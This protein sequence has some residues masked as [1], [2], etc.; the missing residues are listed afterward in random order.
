MNSYLKTYKIILTT[1]APVFIG[2]GKDLNKKEYI[3]EY[4]KSKVHIPDFAKMF[5]FINKTHRVEKFQDYMLNYRGDFSR[6]LKDNNIFPQEYMQWIDYSLFVDE[7]VFEDGGKNEIHTC[8]KDAYGCPYIPGS[9]LKGAIRTAL[10]ANDILKNKGK[11]SRMSSDVMRAEL[12]GRTKMLRQETDRIEQTA[13]STLNRVDEKGKPIKPSNAVNDVM[14]GIRISDSKPLDKNCLILC[15][16]I[17]ESTTGVQKYMP[18][19]RE[20]IKP[21]TTVEFDLTIDTTLTEIT[22]NNIIEAI[23]NFAKHN[24]QNFDSAF[25][26]N[27]QL[28][29]NTIVLGGGA[30]YQTKTITYPLLGKNPDSVKRTS[31]IISATL[32]K[33]IAETHKHYKDVSL[34]ISP[35]TAKRTYYLKKKY[36]MGVCTIEIK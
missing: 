10:L 19:L 24:A 14:S 27:G 34:G 3:Y 21:D 31:Q 13:F 25:K 11:Y 29:S 20:C 16:K 12:K 22:V 36:T 2:S 30:G 8:M 1:K 32:G 18:L 26:P 15:R 33:K 7:G 9:S 6:W 28:P 23:N 35:H 4:H 17:D 5:E